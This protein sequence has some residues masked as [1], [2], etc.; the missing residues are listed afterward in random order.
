MAVLPEVIF[1]Q[2]LASSEK[3]ERDKAVGRLT[4]WFN[5]RTQGDNHFTQEEMSRVWKGLFYCFWMSDKPLIQEELAENICSMIDAFASVRDSVLFMRTFLMTMER[6][7]FGLDKWRKDKY[8]QLTRRFVRKVFKFNKAKNWDRRV[9]E[10]LS[11]MYKSHCFMS[12]SNRNGIGFRL[13]VIDVF[14]EELAKVR[15]EEEDS[16]RIVLFYLE[17]AFMMLKWAKDKRVRDQA[18]VC[19]FENLMRQSDCGLRWMAEKEVEEEVKDNGINI[20]QE[21]DLEKDEGIVM[22]VADKMEAEN[23]AKAT[24]TP[25]E[26]PR[27]GNVSIDIPQLQVDYARLAERCFEVGSHAKTSESARATLYKLS[28]QFQDVANDVF[29]LTEELSAEQLEHYDPAKLEVDEDK[30]TDKLIKIRD[31]LKERLRKEEEET[32][33]ILEQRKVR[34]KEAQKIKDKELL[35]F[36]DDYDVDEE[37]K[38]EIGLKR[39]ADQDEIEEEE[40]P[41]SKKARMEDKQARDKAREKKH[42]KEQKRRKRER[43][44]AEELAKQEELR[45]SQVHIDRDLELQSVLTQEK[46]KENKNPK[47]EKTAASSEVNVVEDTPKTNEKVSQEKP[48]ENKN[49]KK[50]KTAT[51]P[52]VK[53]AEEDTPKTNEK[54]SQE[55]PKENENPKKDKTAASPKVKVAEEDTPKT[56]EKVSQEKK[57]KKPMFNESI[58]ESSVTKKQKKDKKAVLQPEPLKPNLNESVVED[59]V[60]K[61]K[62]KDKKAV[63]QPIKPTFN[64]SVVEDSVSKKKKK[65]KK[66]A[67]ETATA[68]PIFIETKDESSV[69]KKKKKDEKAAQEPSV[70][71]EPIAQQQTGDQ[72][73][74]STTTKKK[75]Q[76]KKIRDSLRDKK[77][78]KL[79]KKKDKKKMNEEGGKLFAESDDW[80]EPAAPAQPVGFKDFAS[81][82]VTTPG[83]NT[84]TAQFLKKALSKSNTPKKKLSQVEKLKTKASSSE[85]KAKRL[86]WALSKNMSTSER[87]LLLTIKSSPGI[88]HD[89]RKKPEKGLLKTKT[90]PRTPQNENPVQ[91]NTQL[92]S[93]SK[94][95][96]K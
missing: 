12:D 79:E 10:R 75:D 14:I 9:C 57:N 3:E 1:A 47:I 91:L 63:L 24:Q 96:L 19:F 50:E 87:D 95:V 86:S 67:L 51:S 41:E 48:K 44:L 52:K 31:R 61:K 55:K 2:K 22:D 25:A 21:E 66:A 76:K 37:D 38:Y 40:S 27:A 49:P 16:T 36:Y 13:Q 84:H 39:K 4:K 11:G 56:N 20:I 28:E 68:K 92:N 88:P 65:D 70:T 30:M 72:T 54:V 77:M 94:K 81:P 32:K 74:E 7:W 18:R 53:V 43:M 78:A 69:P 6:E 17:P 8:L 26:D 90:A 71:P 15:G 59:S 80:D 33:I 60:S 62:K 58:D 73:E 89:P 42:K 29:P 5:I 46:P 85:S 93:V 23:F 34:E 35:K 45:K 83:K 64:E 82:T